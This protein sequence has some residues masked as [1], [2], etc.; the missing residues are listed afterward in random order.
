MKKEN[1][2]TLD[3]VRLSAERD[4]LL[5]LDQTLL[6]GKTEILRLDTAEEIW[7]AIRMLRVRGAPAI[8]VAAAYGLAL[9]ASKL[10][11]ADPEAFL[12]RF[13][14]LRDYFATTRPTAVNLFRALDRM[15]RIVRDNLRYPF[16]RSRK[17]CLLKRRQ[18][19]TKTRR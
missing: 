5:I 16:R 7:E 3:S 15:E 6:P 17:L 2:L 13:M 9:M 11:T 8:G 18:S 10:E 1:A 14:E 4:C 12:I 19:G